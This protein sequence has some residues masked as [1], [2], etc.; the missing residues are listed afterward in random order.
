[1]PSYHRIEIAKAHLDR[2]IVLFI[3]ENDFINA[4]TL[5]GA[6]E[7]VL[8]KFARRANLIP[9]MEEITDIL[10]TEVDGEID[11]KRI[12]NDYLNRVK[13]S[14]KHFEEGDDELV[15]IEP[16][17]EAIIMI[18]RAMTNVMLIEG[19]LNEHA[20]IFYN[21]I[22]TKRPDLFE[23]VGKG[24][25]HLILHQ[26]A[27]MIELALVAYIDILGYKKF[28]EK[29]I[30]DIGLITKLDSKMYEITVGAHEMLKI[31]NLNA[32]NI[33]DRKLFQKVLNSFSVRLVSDNIIFSLPISNIKA[34]TLHNRNKA[35]G[36]CMETLFYLMSLSCLWIISLTGCL[37]R[38]AISIGMHYES[39]RD[40]YL[41]ALSE[42][43]NNAVDLE[44]KAK[45]PRILLDNKVLTYFDEI[46]YRKGKFI[47]KDE[48]GDYCFDWYAGLTDPAKQIMRIKEV[49]TL[50]AL[51]S[52]K[53]GNREVIRKIIYF[54]RYHNNNR[55]VIEDPNLKIDLT[56]FEKIEAEDYNNL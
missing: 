19:Q 55:K 27:P 23:G 28:A 41:F 1:M 52:F 40:H 9:A 25:E 35:I 39:E 5:A 48:C 21:Y 17:A 54:A 26:E 10:H 12:R 2:A 56:I 45:Y 33:E 15:E 42:A 47:Y 16:E 29:I 44:K 32:P 8:G 37:I 30:K 11:K 51:N 34:D 24:I 49:I 50:N 53:S 14:L 7:E 3:D 13:N 38:G 31:N 20:K 6:A 46:L 4:I 36:Y 18:I 43:H 22:K